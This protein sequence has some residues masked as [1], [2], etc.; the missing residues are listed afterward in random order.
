MHTRRVAQRTDLDLGI[1]AA[2]KF[3]HLIDV[4]ILNWATQWTTAG[5]RWGAT[6]TPAARAL[7]CPN[8]PALG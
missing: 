3:I 7:S 4:K 6:S 2:N 1:C 5:Q 8:Q